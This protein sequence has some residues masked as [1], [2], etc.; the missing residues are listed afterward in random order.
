MR[1]EGAQFC[2]LCLCIKPSGI[3]S[4]G[5][6]WYQQDSCAITSPAASEPLSQAE[7]RHTCSDH[8]CQVLTPEFEEQEAENLS[9]AL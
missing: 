4:M 8:R 7:V 1:H 5:N 6:G 2:S 9:S 3:A